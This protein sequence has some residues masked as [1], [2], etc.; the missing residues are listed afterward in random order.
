MM[1]KI[2]VTGASGFIGKKLCD[3]LEKRGHYVKRLVRET[4]CGNGNYFFVGD[5]LQNTDWN[6]VLDG[7]D[8]VIHL[9]AR[10]HRMNDKVN[11]KLDEYRK[12]NTHV[13]ESLAK[14][15][16]TQ[17]VKRFIFLSS[18]K[19]NGEYT[20]SGRQIYFTESDSP[21]PCD[22]YA[23]SKYEAE[24]VLRTI[25]K[26]S[27]MSVVIIRPPLVY[28]PGVKANF[29]KLLSWVKNGVPIP[30][31][32]VKNK[33]SFVNVFNLVDL[34]ST[35][36]DHP[37]AAGNTFLVSDGKDLSIAELLQCMSNAMNK[38]SRLFSVPL[39]MLNILAGIT[40]KKQEYRRLCGS[41]QVDISK[42]KRDLGWTPPIQVEEGVMQTVDWYLKTQKN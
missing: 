30:L 41:L 14:S 11:D 23:I 8:V 39:W 19:V 40:G 13:T 7:V 15:A 35:C 20:G 18:I 29:L 26:N 17:G 2:A 24:Q 31:K 5:V 4:T 22:P 42:S 6:P 16:V 27:D 37:Q 1:R 33:R 9:V 38:P 25:E 28:G 3:C 34:I 21:V 36:V 32:K 12:L 10:V